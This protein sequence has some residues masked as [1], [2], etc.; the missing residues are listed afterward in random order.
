MAKSTVT[1]S[2]ASVVSITVDT[3]FQN[4]GAKPIYVTTEETG[5]LD[6]DDGFLLT[7][8]GGAVVLTAGSDVSAIAP[9]GDSILHR[10]A[11]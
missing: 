10:M 6:T 7:A 4:Q 11:V 2:W 8:D 9:V 3:V 1:S 5:S